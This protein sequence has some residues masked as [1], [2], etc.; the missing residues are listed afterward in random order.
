MPLF[1]FPSTSAQTSISLP[2]LV[3][4]V[5][6][7]LLYVNISV[8]TYRPHKYVLLCVQVLY[9]V[10]IYY[11]ECDIDDKK[12]KNSHTVSPIL[13]MDHSTVYILGL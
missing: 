13:S 7:I 8:Q 3:F 10:V 12:Y 4:I 5:L 11:S 9:W 2:I 6:Y 1:M